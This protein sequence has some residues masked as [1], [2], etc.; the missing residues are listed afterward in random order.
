[1]KHSRNANKKPTDEDKMN[2]TSSTN[3]AS[4]SEIEAGIATAETRML[5][6]S[7]QQSVKSKSISAYWLFESTAS[8]V[9]QPPIPSLNYQLPYAI[10]LVALL[11]ARSLDYCAP[12][13]ED[14]VKMLVEQSP[15]PSPSVSSIVVVGCIL[16]MV[17]QSMAV[18]GRGQRVELLEL[19]A[20]VLRSVSRELNQALSAPNWEYMVAIMLLGSPIVCLL[21]QDLPNGL[22]LGGYIE[23]STLGREVCCPEAAAITKRAAYERRLHWRHLHEMLFQAGALDQQAQREDPLHY[24]YRY[25]TML[26]EPPSCPA[27]GF[28]R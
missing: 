3:D 27:F 11:M 4:P 10:D 19:K 25:K 28:Q 16:L 8:K 13:A 14:L 5:Q 12:L 9:S 26:D 6:P 7:P 22:G 20:Q 15:S 21:S 17:A 18:T 23:A 24:L 2:G 1:M